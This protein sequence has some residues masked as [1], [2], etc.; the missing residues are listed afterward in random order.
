VVYLGSTGLLLL[1]APSLKFSTVALVPQIIASGVVA[2]EVAIWLGLAISARGRRVRVR[3]TEARAQYDRDVAEQRAQYE[4]P[5]G[6]VP[7]P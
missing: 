3:N 6:A 1:I 2:R 4:R 5:A 7:T